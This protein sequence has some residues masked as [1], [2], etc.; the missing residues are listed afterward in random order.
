MN[1]SVNALSDLI[2]H[3][4][5]EVRNLTSV[6][7][8]Q[9]QIRLG[10]KRNEQARQIMSDP[11]VNAYPDTRNIEEFWRAHDVCVTIS[12][13]LAMIAANTALITEHMTSVLPSKRR[14]VIT[15]DWR[16]HTIM[17]MPR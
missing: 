8:V 16:R 2:L 6:H 10:D 7:T 14:P 13:D 1:T 5:R 17:Q 4:A 11:V 15:S 3:G 12:Q 9:G